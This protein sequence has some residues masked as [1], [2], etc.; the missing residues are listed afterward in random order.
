MKR[1]GTPPGDTRCTHR[2]ED[3]RGPREVDH[4]FL[5]IRASGV[6]GEDVEAT[7]TAA[8]RW[9]NPQAAMRG[10]DPA[11]KATSQALP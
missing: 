8:L 5:R 6:V 9:G 2:I 1:Q 4:E 10:L 7:E 3:G 11:C